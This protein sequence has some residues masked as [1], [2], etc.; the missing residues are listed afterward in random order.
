MRVSTGV[1]R[2]RHHRRMLKRSKGFRGRRKNCYKLAKRSVEK[3]LKYSYRDRK[4]RRRDFRTLWNIRIN[5]AARAHGLSYS[6]LIH[7]LKRANI[8]LNRKSLAELAVN[9]QRAFAGVVAKAAA[10]LQ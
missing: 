2:H 4:V 1:V 5:A 6:K 7:G 9:D 8:A 10:A 3:A